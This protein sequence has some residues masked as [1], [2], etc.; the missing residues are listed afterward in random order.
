MQPLILSFQRPDDDELKKIKKHF[1]KNP[2]ATLDKP[3]QWV[4]R[5]LSL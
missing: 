5:C 1:D 4:E 3:E 2:D